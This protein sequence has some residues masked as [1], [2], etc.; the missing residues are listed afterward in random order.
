[1]KKLLC[2]LLITGLAI[3]VPT[4]ET[5]AATLAYA[6]PLR[7]LVN[8]YENRTGALVP[9]AVMRINQPLVIHADSGTNWWQVKLGNGYGYVYKGNVFRSTSWAIQNVNSSYVNS[10][11]TVTTKIDADVFDKHQVHWFLWRY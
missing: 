7:D 4:K 9:M 2:L 6:V 5:S 10:N 1:L 3:S 8:V 11:T